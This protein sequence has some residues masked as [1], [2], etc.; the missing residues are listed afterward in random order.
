MALRLQ[1]RQGPVADLADPED[2]ITHHSSFV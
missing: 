1:R 2:G